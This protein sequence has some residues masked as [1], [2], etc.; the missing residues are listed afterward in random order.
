MFQGKSLRGRLL[1]RALHHQ[2]AR[3][4]NY[5]KSTKYGGFQEPSVE[6]TKKFLD[7]VHYDQGGRIF[8][9][10]LTLDAQLRF[11]ETGKEF[12]I[13]LLSKHTMHSDVS[14][15]IAFSGEFFIRRL[16]RPHL[17][18]HDSGPDP[19]Q[20]AYPPSADPGA[21]AEEGEKD[22]EGN[23]SQGRPNSKKSDN[24]RTNDD[25]INQKEEGSNSGSSQ[26][27]RPQPPSQPSK[28]PSH[29]E[30]IIDNDSGTYRPNAEKLSVLRK[31][32]ISALPGLKV[33]TLDCQADEEKMK[34][35][36][37]EQRERKKKAGKQITYLQNSSMSSISSSDEEEL[38]A[39]A[40]GDAHHESRY[41]REM[42]K[43]M[44]HGRDDHHYAGDNDNE[45]R[46]EAGAGTG[47]DNGDV[48]SKPEP[49]EKGNLDGEPLNGS[50][51][52]S[53]EKHEVSSPP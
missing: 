38:T 32:L 6:L 1:N 8:T 42:H 31:Y 34:K 48:N 49:N 11:T 24:S 4:Y 40:Q 33:V 46:A 47:N 17:L 2:H 19:F 28:D 20:H 27:Q 52:V 41:K 26:E 15:Y 9:Y 3:V 50:T 43:Y 51:D 18:K 36:K 7:F 53:K 22:K 29:Y 39:R 5:D 21:E 35:L 25:N 16:K 30:L 10:V 23:S 13:D 12:G 37:G 44:G 45:I 14:I